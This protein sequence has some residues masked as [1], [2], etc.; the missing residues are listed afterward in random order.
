MIRVDISALNRS[1]KRLR[2]AA[3]GALCGF[4]GEMGRH[5]AKEAAERTPVDTGKMRAAWIVAE[6]DRLTAAVQNPVRYASFVEFGR[7]NRGGGAFVP[8]QK[9][10]TTAIVKTELVMPQLV[11]DRLQRV[12][13]GVFGD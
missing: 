6:T 10:M 5:L 11:V 12:L 8:G 7:R 4:A 2:G 1:V 9:F 13:G 3:D